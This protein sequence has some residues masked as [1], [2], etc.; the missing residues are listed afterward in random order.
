MNERIL[1]RR[2]EERRVMGKVSPS[3]VL[4]DDDADF[5]EI[6]RRMLEGA[7]YC[8]RCFKS[9]EE[10][11]EDLLLNRPDLI[12]LD[13][14]MDTLT[15]GFSFA[16]KIKQDS[17]TLGLPVVLLTGIESARGYDFRPKETG[18]L[19]AMGVDAFLCKPVDRGALLA[20][21]SELLGKEEDGGPHERP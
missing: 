12:V 2:E 1:S 5:L 16:K 14:M 18:D 11:W 17:R 7:G 19:Q 6:H 4:V 8:V 3:I 15:A 13:L 10:A 21:I 20:K 9:Q